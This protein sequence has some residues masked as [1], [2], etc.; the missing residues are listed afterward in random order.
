ML[1]LPPG[2]LR[3]TEVRQILGGSAD[4]AAVA[5]LV[6][7]ITSLP[8][9]DGNRVRPLLNGDEAYPAMLEAIASAEKSVSLQTYIFDN[10]RWG[11]R[12]VEALSAARARGVEVRVLIDAVGSRYT[13][14][15]VARL[16]KERGVPAAL[17]LPPGSRRSSFPR[18]TCATIA[19]SWWSTGA[20]ASPAE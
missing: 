7:K 9:L 12:F 6:E 4:A 15:P 5:N 11:K 20:S 10:D 16:L 13:R 2:W 19:R 1:P 17:F 18:S 14:P 8:L 3:P